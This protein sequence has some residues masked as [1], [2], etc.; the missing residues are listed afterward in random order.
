MSDKIKVVKIETIA[1]IFEAITEENAERFLSDFM[2]F[3]AHGMNFKTKVPSGKVTHMLWKDDGNHDITGFMHN[4]KK[5]KI[6]G[7]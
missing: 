1:D 6:K 2:V 7:K 3:L 4:G 5:V